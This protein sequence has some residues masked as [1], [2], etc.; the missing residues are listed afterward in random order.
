MFG[1]GGEGGKEGALEFICDFMIALAVIAGSA[2]RH[3]IVEVVAS[4]AEERQH[5][6]A[7]Q[8]NHPT[9]L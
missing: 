2:R 9:L 6:V 5:A 8:C 7:Q 1:E 3:D 4:A